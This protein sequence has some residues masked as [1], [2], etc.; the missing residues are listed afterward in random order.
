MALVCEDLPRY[1]VVLIPPSTEKYFELLA[2]IERR[3]QI[4]PKGSLPVENDTIS[5]ISEHDTGGSAILLNRAQVAIASVAYIWSFRHR[6]GRIIPHQ[7]TPGTNASVLLPFGLNDQVRKFDAF[8]NTIF[9]GSKRLMT[10]DGHWYGDNT[11]VRAPA[12]DE[13]WH[14]GFFS[15]SGGSRNDLDEPVKLTLDGVFFVDGGFAGPNRLGAWEHTVFAAEAH[16]VC[17]VLARE[18]RQKT[19]SSDAFFVQVQQLTDQTD[20]PRLP[21][22]PPPRS[23]ESSPPD[24]ESIRKYEQQI[25]GWK[26]IEM[27]KRLGD[28]AAIASIDAWGDAPGPKLHRL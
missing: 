17:A 2:D 7:F 3:L 24:L 6:N 10:A 20:E 4:R 16:L 28:N 15:M 12:E 19:T 18:A 14:G 21:P 5:R 13:L 23:L 27:R 22:P 11:D 8:W 25:V 26:V 1:G 9:P